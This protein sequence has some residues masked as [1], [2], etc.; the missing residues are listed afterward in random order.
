MGCEVGASPP[1]YFPWYLP[2]CPFLY[3]FSHAASLML[4]STGSRK[5]R[6]DSAWSGVVPPPWGGAGFGGLMLM[7]VE[8]REGVYI[9][10]FSWKDRG[11]GRDGRV[12]WFTVG[13]GRWEVW[14][15]GG[16]GGRRPLPFSIAIKHFFWGGVSLCM[17]VPSS[18]ISVTH[19]RPQRLFKAEFIG[20]PN[21][22][23]PLFVF[24]R[25]KN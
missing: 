4:Q 23:S 7:D 8:G 2:P 24:W 5:G 3:L 13:G 15:E 9:M 6:R 14:G 17:F 19:F 25:T 20:L 16:S 22:K 12:D 21:S 11:G 1:P 10:T 18:W